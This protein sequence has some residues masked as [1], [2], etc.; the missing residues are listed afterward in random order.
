[1]FYRLIVASLLISSVLTVDIEE[2][3]NEAKLV[4]T[5]ENNSE[6][7]E[8]KRQGPQQPGWGGLISG[9]FYCQL[10]PF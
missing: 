5:I 8:V 1:M 9:K 6:E 2:S 10:V 7:T 3:E 4:K